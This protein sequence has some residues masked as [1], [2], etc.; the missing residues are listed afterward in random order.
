MRLQLSEQIMLLRTR[1]CVISHL[2]LNFCIINSPYASTEVNVCEDLHC[3]FG[4]H[5]YNNTC[6]FVGTELKQNDEAYQQCSSRYNAY[7]VF[8][9]NADEMAFVENLVQM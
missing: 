4:W 8:V 2:V 9:G 5:R 3:P 1:C 7:I 6:Y